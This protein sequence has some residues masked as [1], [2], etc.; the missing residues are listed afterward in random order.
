MSNGYVHGYDSRENERL[1]DQAG[2]PVDLLH[3]DTAYPSGSTIP[4]QPVVS[5]NPASARGGRPQASY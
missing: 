5:P 3:A 2:T 1:Q 4:N